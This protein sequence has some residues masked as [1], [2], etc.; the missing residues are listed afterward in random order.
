MSYGQVVQGLRTNSLYTVSWT[1]PLNATNA[2]IP[3]GSTDATTGL[4]LGGTNFSGLNLADA[5]PG[6]KAVDIKSVFIKAIGANGSNV[7]TG[8]AAV[9]TIAV[10]F[11]K[12]N[13]NSGKNTNV[14]ITGTSTATLE[15]AGG[16]CVDGI[17]SE[18][19]ATAN[20]NSSYIVKGPGLDKDT[21]YLVLHSVGG[22]T[23]PASAS[24]SIHVGAILEVTI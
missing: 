5:V 16:T 9:G 24:G 4:L 12:D 13:F 8:A 6:A 23:V 17:R 22:A 3:T 10:T 7:N 18:V 1:I 19:K 14:N 15:F 20:Q 11:R 21:M 2:V